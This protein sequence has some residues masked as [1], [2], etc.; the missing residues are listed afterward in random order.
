M[1]R[2][3]VAARG[4]RG[5]H[6]LVLLVALSALAGVLVAGLA[7]PFV[8]GVG[9][10]VRAADNS[11]NNLP[12]S[13][14]APAIL[15][16]SVIRAANGSVIAVLRGPEDRTVVPITDIPVVM[17]QAIVAIEDDR[18]YQDSGIDL[19]GILR[20]AI[21]DTSGGGIQG[22]STITQQYVKNVLTQEDGAAATADTLSRKIKQ[23]RLA[24][25]L[26]HRLSKAQI[27]D[28][29][30]NLAYFG[31]GAYGVASAAEYYFHERVE[32][33]TLPQA[34]DL[35]GI[36]EDPS[37][38]DPATNPRDSAQRRNTVL[39]R[40]AQLGFIGPRRAA[41]L[42][43]RPLRVHVVN[44]P[45]D[46]CAA[47]SAPFYCRYVVDELLADKQLGTTQNQRD[48]ALFEG[49]F[50][51]TTTLNPKDEQAAQ[52]SVSTIVPNNNKDAAPIA[53]VQP[54]T[55]DVLA[56]TENRVYGTKKGQTEDVFAQQPGIQQF[57]QPGSS[58]KLF[59][60]IAALRQGLPISTTF[61]AP[62]CL[63]LDIP[64]FGAP[65]S[66][67]ACPDGYQNADPAEAGNYNMVTGTWFSVNTFFIQLE[68][69][70]GL[71]AVKQAAEQFGV[72]AD[73]VQQVGG[74]LTVGGLT[75]GVSPLVMAEA[76]ASIAAGGKYCPPNFITSIKNSSG[77]VIDQQSSSG[78]KQLIS[79]QIAT[80]IT[81]I[82]QGVIDEPGGTAAGTADI[83][84]PAAGKTGTNGNYV[85]AWF[86]GYTP[87][88]ATAVALANP[89]GPA[90]T[91]SGICVPS[92]CPL[93][94]VFGGTLPAEMWAK[95]MIAALS[96]V[97]VIYFPTGPI[98]L[99]PKP[100]KPTTSPSPSTNPSGGLVPNVVDKPAG[101]AAS[102]LRAAGF[103]VTFVG[104]ITA[105]GVPL[106]FV[107][108]EHPGAGS[109]VPP[110]S[111][112][113][114]EL[115]NGRGG[116]PSPHPTHTRGHGPRG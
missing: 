104:S 68:A 67:Y 54:G 4:R 39:A 12:T 20:A 113:S 7:V 41:I 15:E 91:L 72:P 69:K 1:T 110:G 11:F 96:G 98:V 79:T 40:M 77:Q 66:T 90:F 22:A 25:A 24:I 36:V 56:L 94:E 105:P 44:S 5:G 58:F 73:T 14:T 8:G 34:A 101:E 61:Y 50:D 95:A 83:G 23:A 42:E 97:P 92:V 10:A 31:G 86:V 89:R 60:L 13:L 74:S 32:K 21:H 115:S 93:E 63:H 33:L 107:A 71:A 46:P 112:I 103:Q 116:R 2:V 27:L 75:Y 80:T 82:L 17:Q 114:L 52:Q 29:Y 88:L 37:L 28:D 62:G 99:V 111:T 6:H 59:T 18:F 84:R 49:G 3:V 87:Q 102:T 30:L 26:S 19:R 85:S 51:I 57:S 78:C 81:G 65:P 55:G 48:R 9:F 64:G 43:R 108:I 38:Y 76:Y 35:A 16:H 47:S 106:G 70:V 100:V 109:R 53:M 45:V